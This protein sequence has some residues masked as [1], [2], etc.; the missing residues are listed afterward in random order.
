MQ[1]I[2]FVI[3]FVGLGVLGYWLVGRVDQF[4]ASGN[5][6]PPEQSAAKMQISRSV[7]PV[8]VHR[9]Q[10]VSQPRLHVRAKPMRILAVGFAVVIL[11]GALL[12]ALPVASRAGTATPFA[13][14]LFTATSATCVT[15]LVIYDTYTHWSMFGQLV[16]L[17]LIQIGGLGFM[18]VVMYVLGFTHH[19]F[20]LAERSV[21]QEA[22]SAQHLGGI[23][24]TGRFVVSLAAAI[25]GTGALLLAIR[26]IPQFGALKGIYYA[27]FHAIS[28]FCNAGFD[29]M[30]VNAP[31]SSLTSYAGDPLVS[32]TIMALIICGGLG[33]I[34]W[35]DIV[36]Y[37]WHFRRYGLHAKIALTMAAVLIIGGAALLFVFELRNPEFA[38]RPPTEQ[39]LTSLFQSVTPRTAG[40]NTVDLTKMTGASTMLIICLML[41][42]AS[43]GST[44]GGIKTTTFALLILCIV[45]V[46]RK[47]EYVACYQRRI[48]DTTIKKAFAVFFIYMLLTVGVTVA[49]A[50]IDHVSLRSALFEAASAIGTVGLSLGITPT[51]S[52]PS[53]LLLA[54]LMY[55]GRVGCLTLVYFIAERIV[56][57]PN[58]L[59]LGNVV[60]G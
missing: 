30:G 5:M 44:A 19:K 49:V 52:V 23:V 15:G 14:A 37:T 36:R 3:M 33:F 32:G 29:L 43:P 48:D 35:E 25:E 45:S 60:V 34:V 40:F 2:A 13:Q 46:V 54:F 53:H 41:I 12:L 1:A 22:I 10:E 21:M 50:H 6:L 20:G 51:L 7:E 47:R 24:R 16:N 17:S 18:T 8:A 42:G 31:F 57:Q 28:A 39:L 59:P 38:A 58:H 26:F 11:A 56:E 9:L 55:F 27:V 4:I